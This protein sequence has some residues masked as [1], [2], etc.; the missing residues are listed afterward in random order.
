MGLIRIILNNKKATFK[1]IIILAII[2]FLLF[3]KN[4]ILDR[5]ELST[6]KAKA[7]DMLYEKLKTNDSLKSYYFKILF[8]SNEI[9]RIARHKFGMIKQG[10][11]L[12]IFEEEK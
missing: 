4:G 3:S 11:E 5:I 6:Q 8:D 12:Y 10:E 7:V 1:I 2:I 9:E